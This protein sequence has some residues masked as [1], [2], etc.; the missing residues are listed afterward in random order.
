VRQ[1]GGALG[2]VFIVSAGVALFGSAVVFKFMPA[3][4]QAIG[5]LVTEIEKP[6]ADGYPV[7]D[8]ELSLVP[9]RIDE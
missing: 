9:I 8:M 1:L 4:Y 2:I 5:E 3:C 7:G 6:S